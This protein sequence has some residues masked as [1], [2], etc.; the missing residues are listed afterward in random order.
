MNAPE[1]LPED[2][3]AERAA[4]AA[5]IDEPTLIDS[6]PRADEFNRTPHQIVVGILSDMRNAGTPIDLVSVQSEILKRK[7]VSNI[8]GA[9]QLSTM[10]G[11]PRPEHFSHYADTIRDAARCR[12]AIEITERISRL[13]YQAGSFADV[14]EEA[15]KSITEISSLSHVDRDEPMRETVL[16]V[17]EELDRRARGESDAFISTGIEALDRHTRCLGKGHLAVIGGGTS[18]GK[19]ALMC[20]IALNVAMTGAHVGIF[21]LE[22]TREE[23]VERW[24][25]NLGRISMESIMSG[26]LSA[27]ELARMTEATGRISELP[28]SIHDD[29]DA[30]LAGIRSRA[31]VWKTRHDTKLI[32]VDYLQLVQGLEDQRQREQQVAHISRQ[33][34]AMAGELQIP[35]LALTQLNEK[36]EV[37]ESRAIK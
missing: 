11:D 20:S 15:E 3:E 16:R 33:L 12:K 27:G 21:S 23:L 29:F 18:T 37:R 9:G 31:R 28:F 17:I 19:T 8:G 2:Q 14:A 1:R 30:S 7:Q 22:M 24:L 6:A 32:V 4:I 34:K 35:V 13:A 26:K 10:A 5:M 36:G 25:A